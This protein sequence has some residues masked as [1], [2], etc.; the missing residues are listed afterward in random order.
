[1]A[2]HRSRHAFS[3]A[4]RIALLTA[5]D[6][7]SWL[8][9]LWL[10][11]LL[12]F[13]LVRGAD[14]SGRT[15]LLLLVVVVSQSVAG[16]L[17][18]LYTGRWRTCSFE[19]AFAI[20]VTIAGTASVALAVNAASGRPL[21]TGAVF[22][23]V[24]I[25]LLSVAGTRCLLR[26]HRQRP[27]RPDAAA[28][29][30]VVFGAGDGAAH[31]LKDMLRTR[32]CAYIPVALLD[33]DPAKRHLHMHGVRVRGD[34][35]A[36]T[37][38]AAQCEAD[39]LLIAIPS[40]DAT[41]IR[42]LADKAAKIGMRTRVLPEVAE[43]F[44]GKVGVADIRPVSYS[45]LLGRHEVV[46]DVAS[47]AGYLRGQRVLVTGAGGSIGSEL[48]RQLHK[49]EPQTLVMLDR[50]ES[51]LHAVQLSIEGRAMLDSRDLV[52]ADIRDR[53][54]LNEVFA[55][56]RPDVVFHAAALKHLPLLEMHPG[57]A[58][59]TNIWG[60]WNVLEA[61]AGVNATR[62]VN[63]STD[64]A[65]DPCCM[66]GYTKRVSERLTAWF[67]TRMDANCLSVRF[68]NVLGSRGSV[69]T[70]FE[71]QLAQG[72]PISVTH[73]DVTRFFMTVEE[74]VRLVIQAGAIGGRGEA[75]VLD[76][77][78]PVRI[79]D[80][81]RRLVTDSG[82]DVTVEFTGLRPGEKLHEVLFAHDEPDHRPVHDKIS[83]V[84]VPPLA[85][86]DI[87]RLDPKLDAQ[88]LIE[89]CRQAATAVSTASY[90]HASS[91]DEAAGAPVARLH[92]VRRA[93]DVAIA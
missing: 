50:D 93:S 21:P 67:S 8:F 70:A 18:G 36:L 17:S 69:L 60:T 78:E 2:V 15:A 12:R 32:R 24:P 58:V 43:L 49:F 89:S 48:C 85:V 13:D 20:I 92:A 37:R 79:A 22:G 88:S 44:D 10:A 72:G 76:M 65:A 81:A 51:A 53:E 83:H 80:V 7:G 42:E 28:S 6:C 63:I 54:R 45:D 31:V 5:V 68:G 38:V 64:K 55:E 16:A 19:E 3:G 84:P 23:A 9:A 71:A 86:A 74:A 73:P 11:T 4:R 14:V 90:D 87:R 47:I 91:D 1:M 66:L 40:A 34:R 39:T 59:K 61:A 26:L 46:I 27:G 29:R 35:T 52:V 56:H 30:V 77:G 62:F 57:E 75:L 82:R 25:A 33:D 41:L